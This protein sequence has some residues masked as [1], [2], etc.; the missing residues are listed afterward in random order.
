MDH[1]AIDIGGRESQLCL[2]SSD[3]TIKEEKRARTSDLPTYLSRIPPARVVFEACAES[4]WLADA[5]IAAHHEVRVIASTLVRA[6]G[7]GSRNTKNDRK[8][9]RVMSEAS[10]RLDLPSVH[11][12]TLESRER[13]TM[14]SMRDC[15]VASRTMMINA[16]RGWMR[17][18]AIRLRRSG[19]VVSFPQRVAEVV[20][21]I[22]PH[23]GRTLELI[24]TL[25]SQIVEADRE[26]RVLAKKDPIC[27][28]LMTTPGVGPTTAVAFKA[29]IDTTVRFEDPHHVAS[30][31]G[32]TPGEYASSDKMRRTAITKAGSTRLRWLLV[33]AAW[34]ARRVAPNDPMVLWSKKIELRRGK[35]VAIVALA[36]K[37]AGILF[38]LWRDRTTYSPS[39]AAMTP[40]AGADAAA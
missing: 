38:A 32:L 5:A 3:G 30:Y 37:L 33:Q 27:A 31:V 8:D 13:K 23:I 11:I 7:V 19:E 24:T 20:G 21:E 10:C 15:A 12:S 29:T 28:L 14:L 25:T 17:G 39:P 1:L 2:R 35:K 22:P 6:L 40:A 34:T 26:L 18:N 9:A 4:F 16:V 36:R